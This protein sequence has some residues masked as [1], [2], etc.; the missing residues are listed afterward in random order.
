MSSN[1]LK[2]G[3]G[4]LG[5]WSVTVARLTSGGL[6][7]FTDFALCASKFSTSCGG[8]VCL[9]LSYMAEMYQFKGLK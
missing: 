2:I 9:S 7:G 1:V 6:L 8:S 4:R 5:M 3:G